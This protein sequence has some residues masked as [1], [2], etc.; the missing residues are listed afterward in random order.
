MLASYRETLVGFAA[1]FALV[2]GACATGEEISSS[3]V[4]EDDGSGGSAGA[5]G[6]AGNAQTGAG[7]AMETGDPRAGGGPDTAGS[8]GSGGR[9]APAAGSG[10]GPSES[11]GAP[12]KGDGDAAT[13]APTGGSSGGGAGGATPN[14]SLFTD[15]FEGSAKNWI[16][17]PSDG[18]SVV[19]DDTKVFRQGT[20]D[21]QFRV[22]SGGDA[23]WTDQAVEARV[24]VLA[25]TGSSTSYFAGVFA[26][27]K[28]LDNHYFVALQSDG[29]LK[30]KKKAGGSSTSVS[31]Q[32]D[33]TI[34]A[35]I[36]YTVKLTVKGSTLTAYLDGKQ[37]VT[38]SDSDIP[39]GGVALGTKNATA[40]FDDVKVTR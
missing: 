2:A 23:A 5:R 10:G 18:W 15:D 31:S 29:H 6:V 11:G 39:S 24:K 28:D 3:S 4:H 38:A 7:G 14:Q 17:A 22:S 37:V 34:Q 25:F 33:A 1:G 12:S 9:P 32:A 40:E 35:G 20:L 19:S 36:W 8:V 16:S 21:T 30:I 26:R 13:I 27:F